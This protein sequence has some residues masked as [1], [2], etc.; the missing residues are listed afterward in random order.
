MPEIISNILDTLQDAFHRLT[1]ADFSVL[2][3]LAIGVVVVGVL[4][5]RR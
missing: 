1:N 5:F 3:V 2:M 4:I